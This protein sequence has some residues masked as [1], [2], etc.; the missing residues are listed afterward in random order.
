L[1]STHYGLGRTDALCKDLEEEE[2][3]LACYLAAVIMFVLMIVGPSHHI[4]MQAES[5]RAY[6][7]VAIALMVMMNAAAMVFGEGAIGRSMENK[8]LQVLE[9][10]R[11]RR[12]VVKD[13]RILYG[14]L[15]FNA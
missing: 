5:K 4:F 7:P 10:Q 3:M 12:D 14:R 2:L 9:V 1:A 11:L 15:W 6:H 8:E 13:L